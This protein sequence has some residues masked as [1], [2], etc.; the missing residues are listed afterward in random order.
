M[1]KLMI[2]ACALAVSAAVHAA[3]VTWGSQADLVE[4]GTGA[5][6]TETDYQFVVAAITAGDYTTAYAAGALRGEPGE[7]NDWEV[8]NEIA[9][10]FPL[11]VGTDVDG[12]VYQVFAK[13]GSDLYLLQNF[14]DDAVVESYTLTGFKDEASTPDDYQFG[15]GSGFYIGDKVSNVPEPTSGLLLLLGV[16]GLALRRRRA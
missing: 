3:T 2:T 5:Y 15:S 13:K 8:Y 4:K 11:V 14:D 10:N 9:G 7:F 12:M 16:A 6:V 1:K